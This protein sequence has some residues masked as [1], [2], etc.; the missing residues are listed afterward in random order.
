MKPAQHRA[1]IIGCGQIACGY[2]SPGDEAVLTHAHALSR[3]PRLA[4]VGLFDTDP[5]RA[6]RAAKKW[7]LDAV[8]TFDAL[9]DL[10]PDLAIIAVPDAAHED[11]LLRLAEHRP[12]MV[13]CEKPLTT[14]FSSARKVVRTYEQAGIALVVNYQRRFEQTVRDLVSRLKS[15]E[16]GRPIAGQVL[17]S[18]GIRHNG[19]HAVDLLRL[20]FGHPRSFL[21]SSRVRDFTEDDPTVSGSLRFDEVDIALVAGDERKFSLFEIDLIFERERVRYTQ[22]G[23]KIERQVVKPDPVFPGYFELYGDGVGDSELKRALSGLME[24]VADQLDGVV[25]GGTGCGRDGGRH[26]LPA[27]ADYLATQQVCELMAGAPLDQRQDIPQLGPG[28]EGRK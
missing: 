26:L 17:Y 18:K 22:S 1:V 27:G 28:E 8:T 10:A 12:R 20:L 13:L 11:Y 25:D 2:D 3:N 7:G 5:A 16:T 19:S 4:C 15:G 21:L 23:L 24:A 9:M 14:S 6:E